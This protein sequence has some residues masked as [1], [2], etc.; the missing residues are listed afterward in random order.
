MNIYVSVSCPYFLSL[1]DP[2]VSASY[3]HG[4]VGIRSSVVHLVA[5]H[6]LRPASEL[7][8]LVGHVLGAL[9]SGAHDLLAFAEVL[10]ILSFLKLLNQLGQ[11]SQFARVHQLKLVDEVNEV[12]EA[13]VQ[14]GLSTQ[15]HDVLKVSVVNVR[16]HPEQTLENHLY[17]VHEVL[18]ERNA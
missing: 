8:S 6:A 14:V 13:S 16:V 5:A 2:G 12:L 4:L 3:T 17:D 18:W 10:F 9:S 11:W 7:A 1:S 15:K